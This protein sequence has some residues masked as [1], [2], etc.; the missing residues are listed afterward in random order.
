MRVLHVYKVYLPENHTG[1]PRVIHQLAEGSARQ[2]IESHVLSLTGDADVV[3]RRI[4]NHYA[5]YARRDL[6]IASTNIL[7]LFGRGRKPSVV[8]YH[9]DVVRQRKASLTPVRSARQI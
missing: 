9:S 6:Q 5:H 4:G 2:G 1:V 7:H 3:T 8:T